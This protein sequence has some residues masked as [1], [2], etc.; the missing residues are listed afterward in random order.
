MKEV[1]LKQ[2]GR[3]QSDAQVSSQLIIPSLALLNRIPSD[4]F[5]YCWVS[6]SAKK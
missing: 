3:I 2:T 5:S 6:V 4:R 1:G